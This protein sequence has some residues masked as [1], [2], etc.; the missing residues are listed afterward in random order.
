MYPPTD[1]QPRDALAGAVV[2]YMRVAGYATSMTDA[3]PPFRLDRGGHES[4]TDAHAADPV[5]PKPAAG[6]S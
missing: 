3:H 1:R 6:R 4:V 2:W 5:V